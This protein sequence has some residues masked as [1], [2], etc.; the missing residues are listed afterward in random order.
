VGL[1]L[2]LGKKQFATAGTTMLNKAVHTE[3]VFDPLSGA[4]IEVG[5]K[6][7]S[8]MG[9]GV[10]GTLTAVKGGQITTLVLH[11]VV[12]QLNKSVIHKDALVM[13]SAEAYADLVD[14]A[15][16]PLTREARAHRWALRAYYR[17][18]LPFM[19]ERSYPAICQEESYKIGLDESEYIKVA[20]LEHP[21]NEVLRFMQIKGRVSSHKSEMEK[22]VE[23]KARRTAEVTAKYGPLP[24]PKWDEGAAKLSWEKALK[25]EALYVHQ[26]ELVGPAPEVP[27]DTTFRVVPY[28]DGTDQVTVSAEFKMLFNPVTIKDA[29]P[30]WKTGSSSKKTSVL[31]G[32]FDLSDFDGVTFTTP[33]VSVV[34]Q[35]TLTWAQA[36]GK[37]GVVANQATTN[38]LY[39]G[40]H[41]GPWGDDEVEPPTKRSTSPQPQVAAAKPA[42]PSRPTGTISPATGEGGP[43]DLTEEEVS[44]ALKTLM[45][46]PEEKES[47]ERM[48]PDEQLET[49]ISFAKKGRNPTGKPS[50]IRK[51]QTWVKGLS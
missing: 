46:T 36:A 37:P 12:G 49:L 45:T 24:A 48:K 14:K 17:F 11:G 8:L 32:E 30:L 22:Y 40:V 28:A 20:L 39:Q 9:K 44:E 13:S 50:L 42:V 16:Q 41:T 51:F 34:R 3:K 43:S 2:N 7:R 21:D 38:P 5:A 26:V 27:A 6:T 10:Y 15:S 31:S 18:K 23:R 29:I 47:L 4:P 19:D 25:L 33:E 35:G 1:P